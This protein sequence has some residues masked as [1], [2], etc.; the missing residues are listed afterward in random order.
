MA[1]EPAE[2]YLFWVASYAIWP[3]IGL[4]SLLTMPDIGLNINM[5]GGLL[6]FIMIGGSVHVLASLY[7]TIIW[8]HH[9]KNPENTP[10]NTFTR[11]VL[12][13]FENPKS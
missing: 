8:P 12:G 2:Q 9:Y 4:I 11:F 5:Y 6:I 10:K 3:I 7:L 13:L 1:L